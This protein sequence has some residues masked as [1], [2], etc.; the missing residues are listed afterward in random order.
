MKERTMRALERLLSLPELPNGESEWARR[1]DLA[2][3]ILAG[4]LVRD[5]Y[6]IR[7]GDAGEGAYEV[8]DERTRR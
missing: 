8:S 5:G 6:A 7:V 3:D 4:A 1:A 2:I